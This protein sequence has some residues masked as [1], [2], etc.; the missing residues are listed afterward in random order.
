MRLLNEK[1]FIYNYLQIIFNCI[2]FLTQFK[3]TN[4]IIQYY[5]FYYH[6]Y[7]LSEINTNI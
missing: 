1:Y 4:I 6:F 7:R 5:L 2:Y 3:I